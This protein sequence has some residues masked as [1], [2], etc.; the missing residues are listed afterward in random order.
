MIYVKLG[1]YKYFSVHSPIRASPPPCK[2]GLC[3]HITE[4]QSET[5]RWCSERSSCLHL[6]YVGFSTYCKTFSLHTPWT[7]SCLQSLQ[8]PSCL[9][10]Q[11]FLCPGRDKLVTCDF[12]VKHFLRTLHHCTH[13]LKQDSWSGLRKD[14]LQAIT[15]ALTIV[16]NQGVCFWIQWIGFPDSTD[17][18]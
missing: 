13:P 6:Q 4:K 16:L 1:N 3:P 11:H 10:S 5:W 9:T 12:F 8:M 18:Q 2:E 17:K 7:S 14:V 15:R